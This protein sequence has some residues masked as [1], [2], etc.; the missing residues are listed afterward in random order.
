VAKTLSV[1]GLPFR[2]LQDAEPAQVAKPEPLA[3]HY[4]QTKPTGKMAAAGEHE[5]AA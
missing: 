4:H 2:I 3:D 5:D 1:A